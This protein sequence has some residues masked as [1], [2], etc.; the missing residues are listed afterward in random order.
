MRGFWH[1][2]EAAIAATVVIAFLLFV[3]A[4]GTH[5]TQDLAGVA[6]EQLESLD[7][8]GLLREKAANYDFAAITNM[9]VLGGEYSVQV[10]ELSGSCQGNTLARDNVAVASYIVAGDSV[11]APREV[12]L[13]VSA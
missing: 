5:N 12:R 10:C 1:T 13:Y 8:Q 9:I 4:N 7:K 6:Y 3:S 2:L 11:Y